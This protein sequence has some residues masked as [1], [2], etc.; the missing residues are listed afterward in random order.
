MIRI[1]PLVLAMTLVLPEAAVAQPGD[2]LRLTS[3]VLQSARIVS[4]QEHPEFCEVNGIATPV[5]ASRIGFTVWLPPAARWSQRLHMIGNGGYGSNLYYAQLEA[6]I[7]RGDVAVATDT[8]HT[9]AELT[10]GRDNPEA[11]VDWGNRAVHESVAAAKAVIRAF[12]SR[13]ERHAYF[14]GS[15][16]GGHQALM[17]AQ[18]HP[19]DF[20]GIIAGAP[21][22]NRTNLNLS[23]LWSFLHN[24]RPGD[25]THAI[26]PNTKLPMVN[27]AIVKSC[28]GMDGVIDGVISDPRDCH[29]DLHALKC[30]SLET[31]GCLTEVQIATLQ[32]IYKGPR[33][34]RTGEQIYPGFPFG[35]EGIPYGDASHPGWSNFWADPDQPSIPQRADFFRYW[36][37]HDTTWD[38]WKFNWGSDVDVVTRTMGPVLNATDP[39]LSGFRRR[40]GKLILFIGWSDPVGSA[41]EAIHYYE[42]VVA[43]SAGTDA[44]AKLTDTQKFARLYLVPGMSHTAGGP[45]AT[46]FS[47]ATRDSAPPVEDSRHDMGLAL[48]DWVERGIA[49]SE[50]I[51]TH[52]SAG[53][54]PTGTVQFQRPLC[55]YPRIMRYRGG[56]TR[57]ASSFYCALQ[58]RTPEN[59]QDER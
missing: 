17:A 45:G 43:R 57:S 56:D 50:L 58:S 30:A 34:A 3:L 11:V 49:P 48:Y 40:G 19:E 35:S 8:G 26:V 14:S 31:D 1:A 33:D 42:S 22:N 7:Q 6:R 27:A 28:D 59:E 47:N 5:P 37:F 12:Y 38:W 15:S 41:F 44:A 13:P 23:F 21:G 52:F 16:T 36:V 20:D 32:T 46:H 2:C 24:H 9:G 55:V 51:A 4:A 10:F 29:F 25:N 53:S 39:D 54:G 18:R